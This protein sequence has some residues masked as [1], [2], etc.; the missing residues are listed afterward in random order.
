MIR[1]TVKRGLDAWIVTALAA[2]FVASK[3]AILDVPAY[4]DETRWVGP[5]FQLADWPLVSVFPGFRPMEAFAGH[6][7]GIH[8]IFALA[9]KVAGATM[10]TAHL[11]TIA[12]GAIGV[13]LTYLLGV[14][15]VDRWTASVA[16]LLL[17]VCPVYFAQSGMFLSDV[18]VAAMSTGCIYFLLSRRTGAYLACAI[19]MVL[20]KETSA[21]I[22]MAMLTYDLFV[23]KHERGVRF[24]AAGRHLI[25]LLVLGAFVTWQKVVTG[26]WWLIYSDP[27]DTSLLKTS[28]LQ[29]LRQAWLIKE[30]IF[31]AQWRWLLS[32]L[33]VLVLLL[34]APVRRR[35][36]LWL[37][38]LIAVFAS[39]PFAFAGALFLPRYLM[40]VLPLFFVAGAWAMRDLMH[41]IAARTVVAAGIVGV[42]AWSSAARPFSNT[43]ELN[44]RY[45]DVVR[46][47]QEMANAIERDFP[48]A[49]VLTVWPHAGELDTPQFGYVRTP[50]A[51]T[52]VTHATSFDPALATADLV[53]VTGIPDTAGMTPLRD[54]VVADGWRVVRTFSH[55]PVLSELFARPR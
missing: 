47:H 7:P 21:A 31:L 20:I 48:S 34:R 29:T 12:F 24:R 52:D 25:P 27:F 16:A 51:A 35:R 41:S 11:V 46:V 26:Y 3:I 43:A 54:R 19:A 2:A 50:I 44:M 13:C 10:R 30:W 55:P 15:L 9:A 32:A 6:P 36:E 5:A 38:G 42:T 23:A 8:L 18:P 14:R 49:R 33:I 17:F 1:H 45:L 53:W 37:F 40:P 28:F 4:W 22:V 39:V